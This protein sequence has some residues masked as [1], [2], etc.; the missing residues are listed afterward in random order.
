MKNLR[1]LFLLAIVASLSSCENFEWFKS[2]KGITKE[3]SGTWQREF[4]KDTNLIELW[5]FED[6]KLE[7]EKNVG[8]VVVSKSTLDYTIDAG[9]TT[10]YVKTTALETS[11][12]HEDLK[13]S[14]VILDSDALYL[15][16]NA[17]EKGELLQR[18]FEKK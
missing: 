6:G 8:S 3:L 15:A 18:E 1:I 12:Y 4:L 5:T 17:P 16:A 13:W 9:I 10:S 7:I 14:I 2:E 11:D